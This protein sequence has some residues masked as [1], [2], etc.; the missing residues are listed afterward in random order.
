[1]TGRWASSRRRWA[2]ASLAVLGCAQ[3]FGCVLND[4]LKVREGKK[5]NAGFALISGT[6]ATEV[7]GAHWMVVYI[8]TVPCN[9]GWDRFLAASAPILEELEQFKSTQL[10]TVAFA[11]P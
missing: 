4:L 8:A 1:M 3:A 10:A 5:R 6:V 11:S 7:A 9:E 2:V